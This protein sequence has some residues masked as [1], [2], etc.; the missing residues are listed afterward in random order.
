ML[1]VMSCERLNRTS[2]KLFTANRA[3]FSKNSVSYLISKFKKLSV[4]VITMDSREWWWIQHPAYWFRGSTN[5]SRGLKKLFVKTNYWTQML[6][7]HVIVTFGTSVS[8]KR[9]R[10]NTENY[11]VIKHSVCQ[12]S[13]SNCSNDILIFQKIG[14]VRASPI[15]AICIPFGLFHFSR[16][17]FNLRNALQTF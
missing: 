12:Q 17:S 5:F 7:T 9:R 14:L 16:M 11:D 6:L 13:Q 8:V 10:P 4:P 3:I 15:P 2:Y 1:S